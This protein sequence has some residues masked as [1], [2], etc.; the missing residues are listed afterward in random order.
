MTWIDDPAFGPDRPFGPQTLPYGVLETDSGPAVCV[1][2]GD[3]A[4]P[5]RGLAPELGAELAGV[6]SGGSLDPLLAAGN[7]QWTALRA[8]IAE[9][10]TSDRRPD[11]A[12]LLPVDEHR[13]LLGFTVAD[14]VD[15][16]SSRHHAEN[17]GRMFR[18]DSEPL[19]PNWTHLPVGY[20]GRAGTVVVSGTDVVRP[21]GQSRPPGDEMPSFGPS[22]RLDIEAEVG[23]VCGGA[24]T[25]RVGTAEIADHV[26]G[27]AL[28]NDW[29]ARDIQPWEY[30]PLGPHLAKSFATSIAGW[31]TP[32]AAFVDARVEPPKPDHALQDYLVEKEPWGLDLHL[33]VR[34]NGTPVSRPEFRYM[35]WSPAQQLAHMT[36][37]GATVRPGDLFA[38]GTVSGPDQDQYGSL[39]ELTWAGKEPLVLDGGEQRT[40]LEDGDTV[41]VV[42]HAPG[43]DGSVVG[44]G[45][46]TGT[47]VAAEPR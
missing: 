4:L 47:I 34:C 46:V 32:L 9:V 19:L 27:V 43:P 42:G 20:H 11:G 15:F 45:A 2:V 5:L 12:E 23:F 39:L 3:H 25:S 38:S 40:F 26:F 22:K 31:I 18:P 1:R 35:S 8:R 30:Q 33:E 16:Y 24:P 21:D 41:T 44:L 10:V 28:V 7:T 6:V 36:V 13:M 17:V 29:S 37:N 14:Y